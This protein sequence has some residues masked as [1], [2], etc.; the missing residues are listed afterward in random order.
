MAQSMA[1][2]MFLLQ[3]HVAFI[4][5]N[6]CGCVDDVMIHGVSLTTSFG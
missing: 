2:C 1:L 5:S 6:H 3:D 4:L